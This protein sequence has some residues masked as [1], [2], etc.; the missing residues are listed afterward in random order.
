[1]SESRDEQTIIYEDL[2][3]EVEN[4]INY[5]VN[6]QSDLSTAVKL[7]KLFYK[8]RDILKDYNKTYQNIFESMTSSLSYQIK[9]LLQGD[10][11]KFLKIY[12]YYYGRTG[13]KTRLSNKEEQQ[14]VMQLIKEAGNKGQKFIQ[15]IDLET[16]NND[17]HKTI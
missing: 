7:F 1:M 10:Y 6:K 11:I 4:L 17:F 5:I 9:Y 15:Y 2:K 16:V 12:I 13:E 3:K 8:H 14:I